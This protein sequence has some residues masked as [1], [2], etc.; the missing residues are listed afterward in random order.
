MVKPNIKKKLVSKKRYY[1]MSE[2][3]S[4]K[5]KSSKHQSMKPINICPTAAKKNDNDEL[6]AP[7]K[8]ATKEKVASSDLLSTCLDAAKVC[9]L[10]VGSGDGSQQQAIV[11]EGHT[12]VL[13]TFYDSKA[14]VLKK[15]PHAGGILQELEEKSCWSPIYKVDATQLHTYAIGKF[16]L[17]IFTFPHTG[18]SNN[19]KDNARSNQ[20]LIRGFLKSAQQILSPGGQIQ[21]TLEVGE[22]YDKWKIAS[23]LEANGTLK[24]QGSH[25]LDKSSF[26]GY[27]HRLTLGT[28]G[29]LKEVPD[30]HG[31]HVHVFSNVITIGETITSIGN[32]S[33]MV[34]IAPPIDIAFHTDVEVHAQIVCIFLEI[35]RKPLNVLEVRRQ[36]DNPKPDTR[37]LNRILYGM[38]ENGLLEQH[39]PKQ[40]ATNKKP[41]WVYREEAPE[42]RELLG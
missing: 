12:K 5:N 9:I 35:G 28:L 14:N 26:P 29:A 11:N 39:S 10:S 3:G 1:T 17:V 19:D 15:Y 13:T 21:I 40:G 38:H 8:R 20:E 22:H 25:S 2:A 23:L 6:Q 31:A 4:S 7:P 37:Q 36:F 33:Q 34:V 30:K 42:R 27:V 16:D 41:C 32:A 24:Y 18:V